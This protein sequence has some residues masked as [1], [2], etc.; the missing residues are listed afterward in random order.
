MARHRIEIGEAP[1]I[2]QSVFILF[3][4]GDLNLSVARVERDLGGSRH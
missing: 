3:N 1:Y 2:L 4:G